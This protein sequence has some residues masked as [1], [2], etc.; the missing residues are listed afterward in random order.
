M[1][2]L[3]AHPQVPVGSARFLD[4]VGHFVGNIDAARQA[5]LRYGFTPTAIAIHGNRQPDGSKLLSGTGN[6]CIM[7]ER[8]YL[9]VL[10]AASDAALSRELMAGLAR[11]AGLHLFAL[12]A[13]DAEIEHRRL[14]E[15]SFPMRPLARLRRELA[16]PGLE[17]AFSVVRVAAEAMPEG[18]VQ[19]CTHH[20]PELIWTDADMRHPNGTIGLVDSLIVVADLDDA[21]ERFTRF[22]GRSGHRDAGQ[23]IIRLD[24]GALVLMTPERA[25]QA[26]FPPIPPPY[27]AA[28]TL[29]TRSLARTRAFFASRGIAT[30]NVQGS[31]RVPFPQELG[32]GSWFFV[33]G[34][35]LAP[36]R[37][38]QDSLNP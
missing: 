18:R 30:E 29:A 16:E 6:F 26:Q 19:I 22:A 2:D 34:D 31:L 3:F 21:T 13:A 12:S 5:A 37:R 23:A 32:T 9:E 15:A 27:G 4:H 36:Y 10:F 35:D 38:P 14:T 17:A 20:T 8:G 7:L 24:R 1:D 11:Y 28:V 25:A 33:E